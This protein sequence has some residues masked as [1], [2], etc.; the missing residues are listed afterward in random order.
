LIGFTHTT[1]L[2]K[3]I[4][5][6]RI[7][8]IPCLTTVCW[9]FLLFG[10]SKSKDLEKLFE[11]VLSNHKRF[12]QVV[13][14]KSKK[15]ENSS[16]QNLISEIDS[17][18]SKVGT[19]IDTE[20]AYKENKETKGKLSRYLLICFLILYVAYQVREIK[21]YMLSQVLSVRVNA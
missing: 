8:L 17:S 20:R 6:I 9:A 15:T 12:S 5:L 2:L 14:A 10:T 16:F 1:Q 13:S 7:L 18:I 21:Y 4:Q 19:F 3:K 11:Y